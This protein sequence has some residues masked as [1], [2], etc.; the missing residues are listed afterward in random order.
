LDLKPAGICDGWLH[1]N[2]QVMCHAG[3]HKIS[4]E[5]KGLIQRL[6]TLLDDA[7]ANFEQAA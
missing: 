5:I 6:G 4:W 7:A 3:A 2:I 1:C